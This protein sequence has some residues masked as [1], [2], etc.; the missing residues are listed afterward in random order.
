MNKDFEYNTQP[1]SAVGQSAKT[2]QCWSVLIKR[3]LTPRPPLYE[4]REEDV[5]PVL[6][7]IVSN[8]HHGQ[9]YDS[10]GHVKAARESHAP[11][12]NQVPRTP[13]RFSGQ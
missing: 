13:S 10:H 4:R 1:L 2:N 5:E 11:P 12:S 9:Y 8:T 6:L 3:F 7:P